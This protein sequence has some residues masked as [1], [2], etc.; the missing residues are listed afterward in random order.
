[1]RIEGRGAVVV[2][3][4]DTDA[5]TVQVVSG[6]YRAHHTGTGGN[7]RRPFNFPDIQRTMA[8][9]ALADMVRADRRKRPCP[10]GIINRGTRDVG[11]FARRNLRGFGALRTRRFRLQNARQSLCRNSE[12]EHERKREN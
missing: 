12:R 11:C 4:N 5:V 9:E 8:F 2:I 3:E 10:V 6:F 1:M 7:D